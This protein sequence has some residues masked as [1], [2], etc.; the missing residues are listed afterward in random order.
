M[1]SNPIQQYDGEQI[2]LSSN[3]LVL[4]SN[5]D[6]I[7]FN[8]KGITHFT[9]GDSIRYDIGPAGS[10]DKTNFFMINSP[11]IQLGHS[12]KGRTIEP[13]TKADAL[14]ETVNDQ[15]DAVATYG[16]LMDAAVN[17]PPL[18]TVASLYLKLKMVNVKNALSEPGNVKSD[19]VATI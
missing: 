15:N 10:T 7:L 6:D 16:K 1:A 8:S 19:T 18:A 14:E 2:V 3:R 4:N 9:S 13:V 5:T 17:F 11:Y 12:T